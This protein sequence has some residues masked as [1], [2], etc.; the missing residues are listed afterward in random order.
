MDIHFIYNGRSIYLSG[1]PNDEQCYPQSQEAEQRPKCDQNVRVIA[2]GSSD[3]CAEFRVAESAQR[4][5]DAARSPD[6]QRH[7]DGS[8]RVSRALINQYKFHINIVLMRLIDY[9]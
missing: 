4:R 1:R 9:N 6:G 8:A 3:A 2:T 7:A 5:Q